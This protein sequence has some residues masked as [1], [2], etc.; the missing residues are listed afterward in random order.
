MRTAGEAGGCAILEQS[1]AS[2]HEY[3]ERPVPLHGGIPTAASLVLLDQLTHRRGG[4]AH[5]FYAELGHLRWKP[6]QS[7]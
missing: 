6:R 2:E 4:A 7:L 1:K 5:C 3:P